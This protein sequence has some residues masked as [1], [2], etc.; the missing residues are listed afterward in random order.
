MRQVDTRAELYIDLP[1]QARNKAIFDALLAKR[2]EIES[3]FE[4]KLEWQRLDTKRA[5][6][7]TIGFPGGWAEESSWP[8][9]IPK[10]V[11]AMERLHKVLAKRALAAKG[12]S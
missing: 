5:S 6:R 7:I 10:V 1:N 12:S 9:V 4:G 8:E 11:A 3:E 2:L